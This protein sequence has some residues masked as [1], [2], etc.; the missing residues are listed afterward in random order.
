[1]QL[2]PVDSKPR[3]WRW[4]HKV[5]M[6]VAAAVSFEVGLFLIIF[7]WLE[8]WPQNYFASI[9]PQWE[10]YWVSPYFRGAVSGVGLVNVLIALSEVMSLR[11]W[12]HD[13]R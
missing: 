5:G 12:S 7:P 13:Q 3:A 10:R 8:I 1:M 2:T 6:L 4:Y 9:A 11:R